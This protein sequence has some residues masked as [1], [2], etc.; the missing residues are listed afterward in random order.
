M[1]AGGKLL[2]GQSPKQTT[3]VYPR[4]VGGDQPAWLAFDRQVQGLCVCGGGGGV[5]NLWSHARS[6]GL[7]AGYMQAVVAFPTAFEAETIF[8]KASVCTVC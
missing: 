7:T 8:G 3:S 2:P 5:L 1:C 4:G 6:A